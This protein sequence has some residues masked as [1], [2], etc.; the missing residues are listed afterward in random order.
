MS[1]S[2]HQTIE[3]FV[4]RV[5]EYMQLPCT[6]TV[7]SP[8]DKVASVDIRTESDAKLLIGKNGQ[9]LQALEH[10]VRLMAARRP[11]VVS[12]SLDVNDYRKEKMSELVERVRQVAGR[13]RETK[14]SEALQPMTSYER[15][16]VHTELASWHEVTTESV[17]QEPQRR[18]V[19][20]PL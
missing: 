13:V 19:I 20:K 11:E 3:S 9:N 16:V 17:G 5:A 4:R 18:I 1:E 6:V 7:S 10:V 15:R 12:V 2:T 14:K 8:S